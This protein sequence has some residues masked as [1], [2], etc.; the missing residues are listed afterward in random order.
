MLSGQIEAAL[1]DKAALYD[2]KLDLKHA[3]GRVHPPHFDAIPSG[4]VHARF[5]PH[6]GPRSAAL[7]VLRAL[8]RP[9]APRRAT[10]HRA[11]WRMSM[12]RMLAL[13]SAWEA[14]P[15]PATQACS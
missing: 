11:G 6:H 5:A 7:R 1:A 12:L 10:R 15:A 13:T 3:F 2:V 14:V 9:D 8:R 4:P